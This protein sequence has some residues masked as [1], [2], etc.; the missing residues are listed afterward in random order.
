MSPVGTELLTQV[1]SGAVIFFIVA[2]IGNRISFSNRF[3]NAL[4][5]GLVFALFYGALAY[6]L[7][8]S[9]V[10]PPEL[11]Q[12]SQKAWLQLIAMSAALVFVIDLF[13][14]MLSFSSRIMN[15]LMAA[16]LFA[17]L[18]A[19]LIYATGVPTTST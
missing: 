3:V 17:V 13:A 15:A 16:V 9:S 10:M 5:T 7:D 18:F 8:K 1:L 2:Y 19:F 14:N 11:R 6:T 4:V 12:A